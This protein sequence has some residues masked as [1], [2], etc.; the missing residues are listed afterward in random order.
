MSATPLMC[1]AIRGHVDVVKVLCEHGADK[2]VRNDNNNNPLLC[3][4]IE[5][6]SDVVKVLCAMIL[7]RAD[8]TRPSTTSIILSNWPIWPQVSIILAAPSVSQ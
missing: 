1:A 5:G 3:A 4:A 6:Q 7:T 2:E 8:A